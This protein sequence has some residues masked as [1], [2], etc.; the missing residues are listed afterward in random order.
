[1]AVLVDRR[2]L[3]LGGIAMGQARTCSCYFLSGKWWAIFKD[4]QGRDRCVEVPGCRTKIEAEMAA[5]QYAEN[6]ERARQL[7]VAAMEGLL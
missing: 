3:F 5:R 2:S 7:L 1:M 4:H 6:E